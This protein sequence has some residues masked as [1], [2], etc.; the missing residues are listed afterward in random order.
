MVYPLTYLTIKG[1]ARRRFGLLGEVTADEDV[2]TDEG[3]DINHASDDDE[4]RGCVVLHV[5]CW[6]CR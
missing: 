6:F 1:T 5:G 2:D 4:S 3:K